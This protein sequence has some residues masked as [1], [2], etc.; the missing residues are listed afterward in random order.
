MR[1]NKVIAPYITARLGR[2]GGGGGGGG[3]HPPLKRGRSGERGVGDG[4][5]RLDRRTEGSMEVKKGRSSVEF[6]F[7]E[8]V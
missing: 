4:V 2:K 6:R 8:L 3:G 1:A 5:M 7:T